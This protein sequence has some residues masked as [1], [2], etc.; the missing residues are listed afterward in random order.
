VN[1]R[2]CLPLLAALLVGC[3]GV[4]SW[5]DNPP[6]EQGYRYASGRSS[7]YS[8][9]GAREAALANAVRELAFQKGVAVDSQIDVE[10]IN[11]VVNATIRSSQG[12]SHTLSGIQVVEYYM[13]DDAQPNEQPFEYCVLIRISERE[14]FQ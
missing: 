14:L 6:V 11:G 1:I 13:V 10:D 12:A 8:R 5:V 4:P 9:T 3:S 7:S 2:N